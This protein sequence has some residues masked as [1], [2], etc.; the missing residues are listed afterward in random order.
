MSDIHLMHPCADVSYN[1]GRGAS[2]RV[3]LRYTVA[4]RRVDNN[5][6][7]YQAAFCGPA[8]SFD[9][10]I[11]RK[12]AEGRLLTRPHVFTFSDD[13]SDEE[14]QASIFNQIEVSPGCRP[15]RWNHVFT[16]DGPR[17]QPQSLASLAKNKITLNN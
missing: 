7:Q 5:T 9:K 1:R 12:I 14:I 11:G 6:V 3:P 4:Y 2:I 15:W 16:A 10:K 13:L 17:C 8:D